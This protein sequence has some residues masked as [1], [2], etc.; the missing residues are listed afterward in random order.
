MFMRGSCGWLCFS[1]ALVAMI[2]GEGVG[3]VAAE[4]D[5]DDIGSGAGG[6]FEIRDDFQGKFTLEWTPVR[7]DPTHVSLEKH[8]GNLTITSQRGTIHR[9]ERIDALS[10]GTQAK[11]LYFIP[12][13]APKGGDFVLTTRIV[14]FEPRTSW[15]QAGLMVYNDDDN[16]LK[17]DLEYS[18]GK[19]SGMVPVFLRETDQKSDFMS[20]VFKKDCHTYWLRVIKRGKM[21]EYAYSADGENY[22]I[23]AERRWGDGAP[24]SVGIF[25]KNGGNPLAGDTDAQFDFFEVR[26]LTDAE[27]TQPEYIERQKLRG[28]WDVV[29]CE[30]SGKA[31][32]DS[33]LSEFAFDENEISVQE[34]DKSLKA[35]YTLDVSKSPKQMALTGLF[36]QPGQPV[37]AAYLLTD[38]TLKICLDPKT[39]VVP[40]E[41]ATEEGD[42]RVLITL[43]RKEKTD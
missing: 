32:G 38:E 14:S 15:Q 16:Y 31:I 35:E 42:G 11:N 13:P 43:H 36:S 41:L 19:P 30:V 27:K 21:Y 33:A 24:K 23:V 18:R 26:A 20:V 7:P 8:P 2:G 29:A 1:F 17:C 25:A 28:A 3:I 22:T 34:K 6:D 9:N 37:P 10:Q 12:N 4:A 40:E 5:Q 39:R